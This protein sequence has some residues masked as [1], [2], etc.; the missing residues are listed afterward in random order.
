MAV[1]IH[2]PECHYHA[3]AE[4]RDEWLDYGPATSLSIATDVARSS[5]LNPEV[6]RSYVAPCSKASRGFCIACEVV[7]M[8]Q[9][10]RNRNRALRNERRRMRYA[11]KHPK[12][13]VFVE[14]SL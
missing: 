6:E 14:R 2:K 8:E 9:A 5:L 10:A 1:C 7:D 12:V 13:A 4:H 3:I 11:Q